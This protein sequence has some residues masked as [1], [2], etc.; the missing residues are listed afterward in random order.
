MLADALG[1][2]VLHIDRQV[3]AVNS[4]SQHERAALIPV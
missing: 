2:S 1:N 4:S 3:Y